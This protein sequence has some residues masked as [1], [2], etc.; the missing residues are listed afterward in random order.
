[1]LNDNNKSTTTFGTY[2][3]QKNQNYIVIKDLTRFKAHLV[4]SKRWDKNKSKVAQVKTINS[5]Q[6]ENKG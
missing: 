2:L 1:M 3:F 4:A 6:C 5:N